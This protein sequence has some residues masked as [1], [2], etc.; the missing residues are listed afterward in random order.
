MF[1]L[2]PMIDPV[3][4]K[5]SNVVHEVLLDVE[6]DVDEDVEVE[7]DED[8]LL[9]VDEEEVLDVDDEELDVAV[10]TSRIRVAFKSLSQLSTL[11]LPISKSLT[12]LQTPSTKSW[13]ALDSEHSTWSNLR[14]DAVFAP[15]ATVFCSTRF[16]NAAMF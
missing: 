15:G 12:Q 3:T 6:V 11:R 4:D 5:L 9:E 16:S 10:D 1:V 8:E 2:S 7:V 13:G 14:W